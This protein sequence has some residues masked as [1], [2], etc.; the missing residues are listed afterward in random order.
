VSNFHGHRPAVYINQ[1]LSWGLMSGKF[2]TLTQRLVHPTAPVLL[3]KNGPLG[4]HI[5]CLCFIHLFKQAR[6]HTH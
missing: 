4:V 2:G 6:R 5:Q 1:R 3:T